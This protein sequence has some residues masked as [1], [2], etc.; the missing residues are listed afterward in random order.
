[1][2]RMTASFVLIAF[3]TAPLPLFRDLGAA[4]LFLQ[5]TAAFAGLLLVRKFAITATGLLLMLGTLGVILISSMHEVSSIASGQAFFLMVVAVVASFRSSV[6]DSVIFQDRYVIL[7]FGILLAMLLYGYS[8]ATV[9][10]HGRLKILNSATTSALLSS[11][12]VLLGA[13]LLLLHQGGGRTPAKIAGATFVFFGLTFIL[14]IQSR[15]ALISM[16]IFSLYLLFEYRKNFTRKVLF[17]VVGAISMLVGAI[18]YFGQSLIN[19]FRSQDASDPSD[20]LSGRVESLIYLLESL[21]NL[22]VFELFLGKG[23]GSSFAYVSQMNLVVPH[24]DVLVYFFDGGLVGSLL[25]LFLLYRLRKFGIFGIVPLFFLLN[26]L[27]TN[28]HLW[29][30]LLPAMIV[31]SEYLEKERAGWRDK[32]VQKRILRGPASPS[33]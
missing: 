23:Y 5:T 28:M 9:T 31:L 30:N 8:S 7:L 15:G 29:P 16:G 26:G 17:S 18:L 27:H 21:E 11:L 1:M 4:G 22:S 12:L 32:I 25:Y 20:F 24:N 19:R 6:S 13:Y 2:L 3:G 33:A 10:L 14:T